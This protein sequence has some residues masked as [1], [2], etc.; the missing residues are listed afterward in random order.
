MFSWKIHFIKQM[1]K[2]LLLS[3]L[4]IIG[5]FFI[6][7]F[8]LSYFGIKTNNLNSFIENKVKSYDS[9]LALKLNEVF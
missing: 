2:K 4:T 3:I 1:R 5:I 7:L 8:Y 6:T 9:R